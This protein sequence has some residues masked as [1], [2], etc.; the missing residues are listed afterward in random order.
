[1][2][3]SHSQIKGLAKLNEVLSV[4]GKPKLLPHSTD[5]LSFRDF[6]T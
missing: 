2:R 3:P 6:Y 5:T 1:M 4:L